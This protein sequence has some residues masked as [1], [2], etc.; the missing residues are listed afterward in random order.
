MR[1]LRTFTICSWDTTGLRRDQLLATREAVRRTHSAAGIVET[2]QRIEAIGL[3]ECGCAAPGHTSRTNALQHLA[4]I[5]AGLD[6]AVL[7]E[8]Q[9]LGQVRSGI[10]ELRSRA[11]WLDVPIAAARR[12]RAEAG[13]TATTGYMLDTGLALAR[14]SPPGSLLVIG[15]GALGRDVVRRATALGFEDIAVASR[16]EPEIPERI[17]WMPLTQMMQSGPFDVAVGCLGSG[18]M[19]LTA[20]ATP[21]ARAYIDLGAPPNFA[22]HLAPVIALREIT[23]SL[24]E[25]SSD[26]GR[27][28][29]LRDRLN[30]LVAAGMADRAEDSASPVGRMRKEAESIRVAE[31]NRIARLYPQ[32]PVETIDAITRSVVNRLLHAPSARLR[33]MGDA[34]MATRFADLFAQPVSGQ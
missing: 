30:E 20:N 19:E 31:S 26:P 6:S 29:T 14:I 1:D 22:E 33:E 27:R 25:D 8:F 24:R 23:R 9:I 12:L 4:A 17:R 34:E 15:A 18:A 3:A 10:A 28:A 2:C 13:F 32:L 5:A 11:P 7:G 21:V 16:A